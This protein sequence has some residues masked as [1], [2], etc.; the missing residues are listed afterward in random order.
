[1]AVMQFR[2]LAVTLLG[3]MFLCIGPHTVFADDSPPGSEVVIT[4]GKAAPPA[5]SG[6]RSVVISGPFAPPAPPAAKKSSQ[7]TT[8]KSSTQ[9][10]SPPPAPPPA[11]APPPPPPPAPAATSRA[12]VASP[13]KSRV[14]PRKRAR[15]HA[16]VHGGQSLRVALHPVA[17]GGPSEV[18]T[19][20][21]D[22]AARADP[23]AVVASAT[24]AAVAAPLARPSN[25]GDSLKWVVPVVALAGLLALLVAIRFAYWR[26]A[27]RRSRHDVANGSASLTGEHASK[28][29]YAVYRGTRRWGR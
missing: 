2:A 29:A 11:P 25:G 27:I 28:D 3:A 18:Q 17:R 13:A 23:P 9:A 1:M 5:G 24:P 22:L 12:A 8:S 7:Q 10:A 4:P 15:S 14:V 6:E 21:V 20:P 19:Q 16:S 26:W